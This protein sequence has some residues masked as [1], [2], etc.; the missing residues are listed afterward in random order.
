[1]EQEY[2]LVHNMEQRKELERKLGVV[3]EKELVQV[4]EQVQVDQQVLVMEPEPELVDQLE[5]V[6]LLQLDKVEAL[7]DRLEHQPD[8]VVE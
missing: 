7:D 5:R 4:L 1:M 3:V 8:M 2:R 6:L